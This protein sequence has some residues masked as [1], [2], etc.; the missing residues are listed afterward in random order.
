MAAANSVEE[1]S[2]EAQL[3]VEDPR[4]D[5]V[6]CHV[7][8]LAR[9]CLV[10]VILPGLRTVIDKRLFGAS[11][12]TLADVFGEHVTEEVLP[13]LINMGLVTFAIGAAVSGTGLARLF[14][15]AVEPKACEGRGAI[16]ATGAL[17]P[18]DTMLE[19]EVG[20]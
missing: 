7:A 5:A 19:A 4:F 6:E 11:L 8:V 3:P 20:A 14:A 2:R 18:D 10:R 16:L 13:R 17:G 12:A 15:P 9:P 1:S